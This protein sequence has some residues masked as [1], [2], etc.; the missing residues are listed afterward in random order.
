MCVR[1]RCLVG[2]GGSRGGSRISLLCSSYTR[3]RQHIYI[4][5]IVEGNIVLLNRSAYIYQTLVCMIVWA[6]LKQSMYIAL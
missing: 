2:G 5:H 3:M 6:V 4:V 1:A